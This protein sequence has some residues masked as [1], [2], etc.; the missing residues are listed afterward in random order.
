MLWLKAWLETRWKL[1]WV[2]VFGVIFLVMIFATAGARANHPQLLLPVLVGVSALIAFIAAIM[3]AGS[4]IDTAS[5]LPGSYHKGGEGS[6]LFTLALPVSRSWLFVVR[7]VIG[8]LETTALLTLFVIVVWLLLPPP[9]VNARDA[10]GFFTV[11]VSCGLTVY[12]ISAC[13]STFCDEGWRIRASACFVALIFVLLFNKAL[14]HS[15]NFFRR[16]VGASLPSTHQIAWTAII[17]ACAL[18]V[19][20]LA[21]ALLIIQ[22][23]EY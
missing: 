13:L 20:F 22:K 18:A 16:L 4:G 3:L 10:L 2:L 23:R 17:A 12:A 8:V 1:A 6:R 14:P 19:L 11:I 9:A 15:G 21:M 7:T 5:T